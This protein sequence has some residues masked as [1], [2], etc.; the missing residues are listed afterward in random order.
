MVIMAVVGSLFPQ[1]PTVLLL[2]DMV[3]QWHTVSYARLRKKLLNAI[4]K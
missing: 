1:K 4:K 2:D 3:A